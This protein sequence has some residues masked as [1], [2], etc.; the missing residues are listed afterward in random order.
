MKK[1]LLAL[2][3]AV[4][5]V[6]CGYSLAG[7]GITTDPSIRKI[8][9]PL[10]EDETGRGRAGLDQKITDMVI[11][12]LLRRGRFEVVGTTVGVDAVVEGTLVSYNATPIGFGADE[13]EGIQAS[14]YT[15]GLVADV[16]YAK[17]GAV[18]PIWANEAFTARDDFDM[19]NDPATFFDKE[20]Q[21]IDRLA[22][23]FAR[24]LVAAMLEAF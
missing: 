6:G 12:E 15:I 8:G 10:F 23:E 19:G 13:G 1:R 21:A 2:A 16:R 11:V 24:N 17:V 18:E 20:E 7:R 5:A 22:E 14:R 9:V 4:S 3:L